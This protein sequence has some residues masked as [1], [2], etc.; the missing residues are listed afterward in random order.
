MRH[1]HTR[2]HTTQSYYLYI[3]ISLNYTIYIY[4]YI[5]ETL[6]HTVSHDSIILFIYIYISQ[7]YYTYIYIY[8]RHSHTRCHTTQSYGI[9]PVFGGTEKTRVECVQKHKEHTV[10]LTRRV[11]TG[12][13]PLPSGS[14]NEKI[15]TKQTNKNKKETYQRNQYTWKETYERD[16]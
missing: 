6:T 7:L 8:M 13:S 15:P 4:I 10:R 5:H 9:W 2:C 3:F 16:L 12:L 11:F 1:S 14:M